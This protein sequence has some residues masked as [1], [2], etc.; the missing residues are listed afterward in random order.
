MKNSM[1]RNCMVVMN[2]NSMINYPKWKKSSLSDPP[3]NQLAT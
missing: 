2:H 3:L 1:F